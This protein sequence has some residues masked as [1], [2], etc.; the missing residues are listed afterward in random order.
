M[1]MVRK[2]TIVRGR[3]KEVRGQRMSARI[4]APVELLPLA[5]HCSLLFSCLSLANTHSFEMDFFETLT[6]LA[7]IACPTPAYDAN[8]GNFYHTTSVLRY[9]ILAQQLL[10][11]F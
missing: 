1:A 4:L 3:K 7:P 11:S 8:N 2:P 6:S 5:G 9:S 10:L